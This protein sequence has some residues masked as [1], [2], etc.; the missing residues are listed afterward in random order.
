MIAFIEGKI[1]KKMPDYTILFANGV[2]YE[3]HIPLSTY[4]NLKS[5]GETDSLFIYTLHKEDIFKLYGFK[6]EE[7]KELFKILL[8]VSGIGAK[9]ALSIL[10]KIDVATFKLAIA[11]QDPKI[12][13]SIEGISQK[14][15]EKLVFELKEKFKK[16]YGSEY[17]STIKDECSDIQQDAIKALE[18]LGYSHKEALET[19]ISIPVAENSTADDIV[20]QS[21]KKLSKV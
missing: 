19:V 1:L 6:S 13:T 7:E 12:L 2:G 4:N 5:Q 17:I 11:K 10:S 21:L 20:Y 15:A 14:R 18:T 9:I 16:F 8:A 3:I